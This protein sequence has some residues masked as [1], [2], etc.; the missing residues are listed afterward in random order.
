MPSE[1]RHILEKDWS[2][3]KIFS[4]S[5]DDSP[6]S[7]S[8]TDNDNSTWAYDEQQRLNRELEDSL[9]AAQRER[10]AYEDYQKQVESANRYY[11]EN[12]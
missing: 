5:G 1:V 11:D 8:S 9:W 4:F 2:K 7:I 6:F 12:Y 3:S 10:E